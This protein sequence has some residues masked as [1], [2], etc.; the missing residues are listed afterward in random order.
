MTFNEPYLAIRL[1]SLNE[2]VTAFV[3]EIMFFSKF[4]SSILKHIH[5]TFLTV[6]A[7][8]DSQE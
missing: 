7:F 6:S 4:N 1:I 5:F 2:Y 8:K 3:L